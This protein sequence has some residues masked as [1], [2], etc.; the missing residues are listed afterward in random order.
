MSLR[1]LACLGALVTAPLIAHATPPPEE[2]DEVAPAHPA[3][4]VFDFSDVSVQGEL[5]APE[6]AMMGVTPGGAQDIA[7]ARDQIERGEV[8]HPNTFTPEGLFS[9]HDL[10]APVGRDCPQTLCVIGAA[11]R[12]DLLV[13]PEVRHVAQL[14]FGTDIKAASWRRAPLNLVAVVDKSGSMAGEPLETVKQTLQLAVDLMGPRDQL[15]IVLYGDSVHTHLEPV[16]IDEGARE[17]VK[18]LIGQIVSAGSTNMEAG[19]A[20]GF[21]KAHESARRFDGISRVM[22]FTDERPNVGRTDAGSFMAMARAASEKGIGMTTIGVGTRFGA[23]LA[24][25]ISSVRGGNLFFFPNVP[26]M[27]ARFSDDFD[28]MVSELAHDLELEVTPAEGQR[29][30]GLYGLP[31]DAVERTARGGLRMGLATVFLSKRKG[32]IFLAFAPEPGAP[33]GVGSALGSA[34]LSYKTLKGEVARD[35]TVFTTEHAPQIGLQRGAV[36]VDQATALKQIATLHVV[37][38]KTDAAFKLARTLYQRMTQAKVDGLD[39]ETATVGRLVETLTALSGR[40]G[41]PA[42]VARHPVHGL[43]E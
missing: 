33:P 18:G 11:T 19:L 32:A 42:P 6:A 9:E 4:K 10:P 20:L 30:V 28:T 34:T 2:E 41:E 16:R 24:T 15:S 31:G 38:N 39:P 1:L 25:K 36:L 3:P 26:D 14:A 13:Q 40:Q 27:R 35:A 21:A 37:E 17:R 5:L 12:A 22:L 43:P 7:S 23:E 8:P 29:I